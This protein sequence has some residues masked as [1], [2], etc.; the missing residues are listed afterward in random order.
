MLR[1]LRGML[2][3]GLKRYFQEVYYL[4]EFR[5][6]TQVGEDSY[7]NRYFEIQNDDSIPF[8]MA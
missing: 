4:R 6:G 7:G 1:H 8:C 3:V 2:R 5:G